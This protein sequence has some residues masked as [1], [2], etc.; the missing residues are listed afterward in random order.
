[1]Q[2]DAILRGQS[3]ILQLLGLLYHEMKQEMLSLL[4]GFMMESW[5]IHFDVIPVD[6]DGMRS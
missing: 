4:C 3:H 5:C 1:M 6:D 2:R